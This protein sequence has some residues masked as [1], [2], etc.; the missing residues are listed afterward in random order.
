MNVGILR[1]KYGYHL[2]DADKK[3]EKVMRQDNPIESQDIFGQGN[4]ATT[5]AQETIIRAA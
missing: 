1:S 5:L 3:I 2:R 4:P